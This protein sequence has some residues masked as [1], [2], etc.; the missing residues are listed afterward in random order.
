MSKATPQTPDRS[1]NTPK[2][3]PKCNNVLEEGKALS[4]SAAQI[5]AAYLCR[6]CKMIYTRDLEPL[7][8]MV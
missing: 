4:I 6:F 8:R 5:G 2:T 1:D 3:C 7:A